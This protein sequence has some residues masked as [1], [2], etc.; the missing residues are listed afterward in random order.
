MNAFYVQSR[1]HYHTLLKMSSRH[2]S[3]YNKCFIIK[4]SY[5]QE[6]QNGTHKEIEV[7]IPVQH[8]IIIR[9]TDH[10]PGTEPLLSFFV[11]L[12]FFIFYFNCIN[13]KNGWLMN[14]PMC[15][16]CNKFFIYFIVVVFHSINGVVG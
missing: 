16:R 4:I 5:E 1:S 11:C 14:S 13:F 8:E 9:V 2:L 12:Y 7:K 3:K 10:C 6:Q 15:V